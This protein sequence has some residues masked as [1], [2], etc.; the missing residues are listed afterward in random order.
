MSKSKT[1]KDL[2][3]TNSLSGKKEIFIPLIEGSVSFYVCGVTV[4]DRCHIGHG[5]AYV[6]FDMMRRYL[7]AIGFDVKYV[8]NFTDIDDK[9]ITRAAE[10][11]ITI[12]ALTTE[13]IGQYFEDMDALNISRAT[14][15]PRAT[16]Y[17]DQ[18][19][20][21]IQ[22]LIKKGYAYVANQEVLFE[23]S[24]FQDYGKLSKKVLEDLEQGAR[25]EV[26]THKKNP[27]DFVLWKPSKE[28]EP[29]WDSPWGP[30][31]PGWHIECSAMS[32]TELGEQFDIHGGGEDLL[33]PHHE[34]EIAQS[35]CATGSTF[36]NYWVHNGFVTIM[37]E[38]M[39]KSLKN[40]ITVNEIL[41]EC[42]GEALRFYLLKTHY[43]KPL[44]F[45]MEGLKESQS[46]LQRLHHTMDTFDTEVDYSDG[47]GF[48]EL[49]NR[50]H[51]AMSDNF[52]AAEAIGVLF[53][54]NKEVHAKK[55]GAKLLKKLG[56][57][58]GLFFED[59]TTQEEFS[60]EIL[61]LAKQRDL[62]KAEKKYQEADSIRD[63]L[64]TQ[65]AI[66]IEDTKEGTKLKRL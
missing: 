45:S 58:L 60:E 51:E 21:M 50:F 11:G 31:R 13:T 32:V 37:N 46:A 6:V 42:S 35:V 57:I 9:I 44:H 64:K 38:K 56:Q 25:V 30:G 10:R 17:M 15:Y 41:N 66:L 63:Q 1:K 52:N 2:K 12:Q 62:A 55:T 27:L 8:Q 33:F 24:K 48:E 4:Y 18:M 47:L 36:A 22:T 16:N 59:R 40:F 34:N 20:E 5:R 28:G 65:Y 43:R 19:I 49:E 26:S 14:Q 61:A 53:D 23:V 3:I 7:E 39:S 54:L 29:Y